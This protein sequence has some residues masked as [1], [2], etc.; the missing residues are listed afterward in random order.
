[1]RST[2]GSR[3]KLP[4]ERKPVL[5]DDN[6]DDDD[7]DDDNDNDDNPLIISGEQYMYKS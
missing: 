1:V 5:I 6:D 4:G 7:D 2:L 3:G